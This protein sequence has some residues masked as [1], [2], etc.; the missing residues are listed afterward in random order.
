MDRQIRLSGNKYGDLPI[1]VLSVHYLT[2]NWFPVGATGF[3]SLFCH[4]QMDL[5]VLL[6]TEHLTGSL[7][8]VLKLRNLG[9]LVVLLKS[10]DFTNQLDLVF[11][12]QLFFF[13]FFTSPE[14]TKLN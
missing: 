8:D 13:S 7:L 1:P 14:Y 4:S 3:S 9:Y 5:E 2:E 10:K 11:L 12:F 6:V